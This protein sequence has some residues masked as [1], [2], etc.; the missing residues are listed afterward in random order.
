[1]EWSP[2]LIATVKR[3]MGNFQEPQVHYTLDTQRN[4]LPKTM[5]ARL[6]W[7]LSS[8]ESVADDQ[9]KDRQYSLDIDEGSDHMEEVSNYLRQSRSKK[10]VR[11]AVDWRI[12]VARSIIDSI[13]DHEAFQGG[14]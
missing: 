7:W 5:P 14:H 11:F 2:D 6:A 8:V 12:A 4:P 3:S 9:L 1:M 10:V 13:K